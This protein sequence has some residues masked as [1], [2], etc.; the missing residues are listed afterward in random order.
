MTRAR[1]A[2]ITGASSGIGR[3]LA[4]ALARE[5]WRVAVSARR[6]TLLAELERAGAPGDI[7]SY[8]AD[9]TEGKAME[10]TADRIEHEL[11]PIQLAI[12]NAGIGRSKAGEVDPDNYRLHMRVN[13]LGV[14][15]GIAAVL[16]FMRARREGRIVLV[17][18]LAGYRGLPGMAPYAA[19]KAALNNLAESLECEIS[20]DG[21]HMSLVTPGFVATEMTQHADRPLPFL[22][23]VDRAAAAIL[24]GVKRGRFRIAFPWQMLVLS[25]FQ[26]MIPDR[27]YFKLLARR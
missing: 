7:R 1:V 16:P 21:I 4:L 14:V 20:R 3:A 22:I 25:R 24:R 23:S 27:I 18:S 8:P 6:T 12:L 17:S 15:N 19:S 5:G 26:R 13:Y 10:Q 2:W 9:V 11:G